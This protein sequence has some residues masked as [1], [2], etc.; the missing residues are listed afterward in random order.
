MTERWDHNGYPR[1]GYAYQSCKDSGAYN[2][3]CDVCG[4]TIRYVHQIF[5]PTGIHLGVGLACAERLTN[6]YETPRAAERKIKP[7][8]TTQIAN[9]VRGGW[10]TAK[11]GGYYRR[12][13]KMVVILKRYPNGYSYLI[14]ELDD[15]RCSA[16][17]HRGQSYETMEDAKIAAYFKKKEILVSR[18]IA[19]PD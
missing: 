19:Q 13:Q 2:A 18:K 17:E 3:V 8:A 6:D 12:I 14:R 9:W 4:N 1:I 10:R 7:T 5:H 11:H 15:D 16:N